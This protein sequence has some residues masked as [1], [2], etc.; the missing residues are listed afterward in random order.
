MVRPAPTGAIARPPRP[1][2]KDARRG[3]AGRPTAPPPLQAC[4]AHEAPRGRRPGAGPC[5]GRRDPSPRG[6][7][8]RAHGSRPAPPGSWAQAAASPRAGGRA[9]AQ[10]RVRRG[11]DPGP[12]RARPPQRREELTAEETPRSLTAATRR[13]GPGLAASRSQRWRRLLLPP[14]PPSVSS[15]LWRRRRRRDDKMAAPS[16]LPPW[17]S[18]SSAQATPPRLPDHCRA[19]VRVRSW[20]ETPERGR[21]VR[22]RVGPLLRVRRRP[23]PLRSLVAGSRWGRARCRS[24]PV[25]AAP[26]PPQKSPVPLTSGKAQALPVLERMRCGHRPSPR[27]TARPTKEGAL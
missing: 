3:D 9:G 17:R 13:A 24:R 2:A 25:R 5:C 12:S 7:G 19:L 10:G 21:G 4:S 18:S 26:P 16:F 8:S 1:P 27:A 11:P 20:G 23:R 15:G 14:P 6:G 22:P